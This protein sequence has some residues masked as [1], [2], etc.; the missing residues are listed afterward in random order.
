MTI[1]KT[2]YS[3]Q[4]FQLSK[5]V[6]QCNSC[7]RISIPGDEK[8]EVQCPDCKEPMEL[9]TEGDSPESSENDSKTEQE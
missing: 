4:P 6:Y 2:S 5:K 8:A 7:G 1:A 3:E 9:I